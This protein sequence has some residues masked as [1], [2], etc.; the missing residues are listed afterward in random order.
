MV[1]LLKIVFF[2]HSITSVESAVIRISVGPKQVSIYGPSNLWWFKVHEIP[3]I[4]IS[5]DFAGEIYGFCRTPSPL[6]PPLGNRWL[7][8]LPS[9]RQRWRSCPGP[10]P[11]VA[12]VLKRWRSRWPPGTGKSR[13]SRRSTVEATWTLHRFV[14]LPWETRYLQ[15]EFVM[16]FYGKT[17]VSKCF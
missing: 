3:Q 11:S 4:P 1:Y 14:L 2:S 8:P 6:G 15:I 13:R 9:L 10:L 16:F 17:M 7:G 12:A 5:S